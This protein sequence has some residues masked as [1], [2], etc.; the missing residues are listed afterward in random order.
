MIKQLQFS[1]SAAAVV[2]RL[3]GLRGWLS[4]K[5][6]G[7]WRVHPLIQ[8]TGFGV[9]GKA[10]PHGASTRSP[11][12]SSTASPE[13]CA[14]QSCTGNTYATNPVRSE[15]FVA[16]QLMIEVH[17]IDSA[18]FIG[19]QKSGSQKSTNSRRTRARRHTDTITMHC[20]KLKR[21]RSKFKATRDLPLPG[22]RGQRFPLRGTV[23]PMRV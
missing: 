8:Q 23:D 14:I 11:T 19:T 17:P 20:D 9:P 5:L 3:E 22:S 1:Y 7:I 6:A 4:P 18:F 16:T 12:C 2:R 10:A 15:R 13:V 21:M